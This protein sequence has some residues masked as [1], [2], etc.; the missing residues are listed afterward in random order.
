MVA[1]VRTPRFFRKEMT[2][3]VAAIATGTENKTPVDERTTFGLNKSVTGSQMITACTP[4][5][6]AL[7]RMVP[8]FPGFSIAS[9]TSKNGSSVNRRSVGLLCHW[10]ATASN[11]SGRSR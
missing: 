6:S 11:P 8:R 9:I 4:A 2:S 7:R 10:S 3:S 5:A 1:T